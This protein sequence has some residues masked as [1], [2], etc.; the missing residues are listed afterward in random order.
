MHFPV[1]LRTHYCC[2]SCPA[3]SPCLIILG[4]ELLHPVQNIVQ[5]SS[6]HKM[7]ESKRQG[8]E[9]LDSVGVGSVSSSLVL[10]GKLVT[11]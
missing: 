4:A 6:V 7:E 1:R 11:R 8:E 10:F 3:Q 5:V 2:C 9:M